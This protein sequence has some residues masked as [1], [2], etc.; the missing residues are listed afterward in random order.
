MKKVLI[1]AVIH[2]L[3]LL[4]L[5]AQVKEMNWKLDYQIYLKMANDSN[6]TY[7]I[8]DLFPVFR[9]FLQHPYKLL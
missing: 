5:G 1:V 4:P 3:I 6:Y 2:T 9:T 8:R 7:D